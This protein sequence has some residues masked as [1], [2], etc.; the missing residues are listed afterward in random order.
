[1]FTKLSA[2]LGR[3]GWRA[4]L[5]AAGL[6]LGLCAGA[7]E[8]PSELTV[9]LVGDD[10]AV[11]V[12]QPAVLAFS[13]R[14]P[15]VRVRLQTVPWGDAVVKY[16]AA[17]ASKTG[18]DILTAGLSQAVEL[19]RR[20]GL[21]DMARAAP[22]FAAAVARSGHPE[23]IKALRGSDGALYGMPYDLSVQLQYLRRD[24]VAKAPATWA[25]LEQE[26]ARQLQAGNR[27]F[28]QQW[29]NVAWIG[30]FPFLV[31]AGGALY[32]EGCTRSTVD[33][34]QAVQALRFYASLYRR[35]DLSTD[36]SPDMD[37]ALDAGRVALGQSYA[38]SI[39]AIAVAR[40][41]LYPL[42][43]LAPL[44]AGPTGRRTAFLGG[45][46][47]GIV[48]HSPRRQLAIDFMRSVYQ[49]AMMSEIMAIAWRRNVVWVPGAFPGLVATSPLPQAHRD[50][51]A[52]Q[53]LDAQGP[54]VC[55]G[56]QRVQSAVTRA[57]QAVVVGG[58]DP[59]TALAKAARRMNLALR[60]Q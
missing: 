42:L 43:A 20:G 46:V 38:S 8:R 57:V 48:E 49:P 54:P 44:P 11:H 1:M 51:L 15:G 27:G 39:G 59:A 17:M 9:W 58:E 3:R 35:F 47:M 24:M 29:G 36:A 21:V 32:D 16:S 13:Q 5:A 30:Y 2:V 4:S 56:W 50:A 34:P 31:Q 19:G 25:E 40:P 45:T 18:P 60:P 22:D 6:A 28:M 7:S 41:R 14:H 52:A 53:L 23:L 33:S 10:M 55:P 12:L 26:I 37:A